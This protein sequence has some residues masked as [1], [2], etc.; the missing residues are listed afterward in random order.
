[1]KKFIS[2]FCALA[3]LLLTLAVPTLNASAADPIV[4]DGSSFKLGNTEY[5]NGTA[6][7]NTLTFDGTDSTDFAKLNNGQTKNRACD[8]FE[9]ITGKTDDANHGKV[10]KF[11]GANDERAQTFYPL[12][13]AGK[14][15]T[16]F[17]YD[18]DM[19]I[20]GDMYDATG[21]PFSMATRN[22]SDAR[23]WN[24]NIATQLNFEKVDGDRV[25]RFTAPDGT[26]TDLY[27]VPQ[28]TWFRFTMML[29][30]RTHTWSVLING[31]PKLVDGEM[32]DKATSG[33]D[34]IEATSRFMAND[35][36]ALYDNVKAYLYYPRYNAEIKGVT[37]DNTLTDKAAYASGSKIAVKF[38]VPMMTSG[39]ASGFQLFSES[40]NTVSTKAFEEADYDSATNTLY[41][42][43]N[44]DL[45]PNSE[46]T[47]ELKANST[48]DDGTVTYGVATADG[49]SYD[50]TVKLKIATEK[51][52]VGLGEIVADD[53]TP[54]SQCTAK[55]TLRKDGD[56]D[57]NLV[58]ALYVDGR[59]RHVES[60]K[61]E[62]MLPSTAYAEFVFDVPA[63]GKDYKLSAMLLGNDYQV[64]DILSK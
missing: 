54:G 56:L 57:A 64:I 23:G 35:A 34:T 52:P 49:I 50:D 44:E 43:A 19:Y 37:S 2:I 60:L 18:T 11:Y 33:I 21:Q 13:S 31:E 40:G 32:A 8:T 25:L 45:K 38:S 20:K 5:V 46:Y 59:M 30:F 15:L 48:A 58:L 47:L 51:T 36:Y 12:A 1:M 9:N 53:I 7:Y 10:A 22:L 3:T 61:T 6:Y 28:E 17:V 42:T 55:V 24:S 63:G 4:I 16:T 27:T 29:D 26:K 62:D 41:I 39:F 14:S